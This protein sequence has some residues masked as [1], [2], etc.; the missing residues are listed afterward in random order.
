MESS[1]DQDVCEM[2]GGGTGCGTMMGFQQPLH[3][4]V[5]DRK[6]LIDTMLT[7]HPDISPPI[8]IV[9][10]QSLKDDAALDPFCSMLDS[11]DFDGAADKVR[12]FTVREVVRKKLKEIV[13]KKPGGGGYVL[14]KPNSG[15]KKKPEPAG[16]F[17]TLLGAKQAE[18]NRFPPK[19]PGRLN[20]LRKTVNRLSH[21]KAGKKESVDLLRG[22][23]RALVIEA[24]FREESTGSKWDDRMSGLSPKALAADN[25]LQK[26]VGNI[27]SVTADV[28]KGAFG[29]IKKALK[30]IA[31]L[32]GGEV[33]YNAEGGKTYMSLTAD[34]DGT[35]VGPIYVYVEHGVPKIEISDQAKATFSKIDPEKAKR[36]RAELVA[37]QEAV[38]KNVKHL[39][40]AIAARDEYLTS[41]EDSIDE[42]ISGLGPLGLTIMKKLLK[43]KYRGK[44]E[45]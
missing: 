42:I 40:A 3:A 15:K 35:S 27:Q 9:F 22:T 34:V 25:R 39:A 10:A 36:L 37:V 2:D 21:P 11:G 44:K 18:L 20:R 38:P 26:L 23:I 24:L 4:K 7:K 28:L 14:Y 12:E 33:K 19:D 6:P 45:K 1:N 17:P 43:D 8:V 32:D 16:S 31:T 5:V 29:S 13:R 30:G 41:Q